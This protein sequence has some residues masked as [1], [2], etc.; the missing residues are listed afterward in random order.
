[1]DEPQQYAECK[2]CTYKLVAIAYERTHWFRFFREP[3]ILGMRFFAWRHRIRADVSQ[4]VMMTAACNNCIRFYKAALFKKSATF[5]WL[6]S[7]MNPV[8]NSLI[9]RIVT[10]DERR[11]A[12][13]Y[14]DAATAG[15][16]SE[17]EVK[18]WMRGLKHYL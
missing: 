10:E 8:F 16:L 1:M 6:H 12:R 11:Q 4:Y 7:R 18:D 14:A 3:L 9:R 15:T 17:A 13:T 2:H 5:R